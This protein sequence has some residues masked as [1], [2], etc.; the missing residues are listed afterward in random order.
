MVL[1]ING[2]K[3]LSQSE[4]N[5]KNDDNFA[6]LLL[7]VF[8]ICSGAMSC[9]LTIR[10][11][12]LLSMLL[13]LIWISLVGFLLLILLKISQLSNIELKKLSSGQHGKFNKKEIKIK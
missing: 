9:F 13:F 2:E 10:S 5:C 11:D 8:V 6:G 12:V 3:Y 4:I 1:E 7:S